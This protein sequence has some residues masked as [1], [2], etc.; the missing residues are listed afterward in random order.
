MLIDGLIRGGGYAESDYLRQL[1]R[2]V[3][4]LAER[5]SAVFVGRGSQYIIH[6]DRALRVRL[7]SPLPARIKTLRDR[8]GGGTD[9]ELRGTIVRAERERA[10]FIKHNFKRD[11]T[12]PTDYDLVLNMGSL[13]TAQACAVILAAYQTRFPAS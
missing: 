13:T 8:L 10:A 11:L 3:G 7:V 12:D 6:P 1:V 9:K 2:V 5:G 4:A